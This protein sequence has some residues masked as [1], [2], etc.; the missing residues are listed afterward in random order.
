MNAY[1]H[2]LQLSIDHAL[3]VSYRR[4][5]SQ[6]N[7]S[8]VAHISLVKGTPFYGYYEGY[9]LYLK[10]Y[11]L[12][13]LHIA[14]LSDLLL[15][16]AVMKKVFQPYESHLQY[17]LQWMCDYNLYGCDYL[18][19]DKVKFRAPVP[20]YDEP[21]SSDHLWHDMSIPPESISD[22]VDVLRLSH[23]TVEV[24][25]HVQEIANRRQ[26]KARPIHRDFVERY[27]SVTSDER[28]VHSMAGLWRDETRRRKATM[29]DSDPNSTP[30]PPEVLISMS[31]QPR[32]SPRSGWIHEDEYMQVLR[33]II[34]QERVGVHGQKP[35]FESFAEKASAFAR[36]KSALE[37]V[38]DLY[39]E[40]LFR[41]ATPKSTIVPA[42]SSEA[43]NRGA[44]VDVDESL[45]FENQENDSIY[46][47]DQDTLI[48]PDAAAIVDHDAIEKT[49]EKAR[50]R[51]G[52]RK[53]G[54]SFASNKPK[55]V[56]VDS[57][58]YLPRGGPMTASELAE[59]GIYDANN[60]AQASQDKFAI[61]LD[62][63]NGVGR[64]RVPLGNHVTT[65]TAGQM[66]YKRRK[67]VPKA[68]V[69]PPEC[70]PANDSQSR[71]LG[72][73][74]DQPHA[75]E[76]M[77]AESSSQ[78][79]HLQRNGS[80]ASSKRSSNKLSQETIK[81]NV[82]NEKTWSF[83]VVKDPK[84]VGSARRSGQQNSTSQ[85]AVTPV[86]PP[87]VSIGSTK[88]PHD[89]P[90]A[91]HGE[92]SQGL[93]S[94][95]SASDAI[96]SELASRYSAG[97]ASSTGGVACY[98]FGTAPPTAASV[99]SEMHS[100]QSIPVLYQEAY[101]SDERDVPPRTREYAG[102]GFRLASNT[103]PYLPDFDPDGHSGAT[104]GAANLP[105]HNLAMKGYQ[106]RRR[107]CTL[108]AWEVLAIP[109]SRTEVEHWCAQEQKMLAAR[110]TSESQSPWPH[111]AAT[112]GLS[113]IDGPTQKHRHGFKFSQRRKSSAAPQ[114]AQYMSL[115]SL[116]IH[117]NNR[118]DLLPNPEQD[119]ITCV[120]W[121]HQANDGVRTGEQA[122]GTGDVGILV[123][124]EHGGLARRI[125][126]EAPVRIEEESTEL[127]L[128]NRMIDIV[129]QH[130]PDILTGYEVHDGSWGY[131]IERARRKYDYNL[132]DEFSR[133]KSQSHGRFG[134][135]N[136]RW[137][138]NHTSTIRVTGRHMINVWRAMRG[139]L[140]LLQYTLENVAFHLLH[141]RIPHY[142]HKD[143]T[144][145][146]KSSKPRDMAKVLDYYITRVQV[147][148]EILEKNE[149]ISRTSEQARILGVD[150]FSV[151]SRGSQF[152]VES[153]MF[154]IAK[155]EDYVLVSPSR[156]QVGQQNALECLPLVMEPQSD[157][158][159]SPL[160]VL[161]FQSL[162]PSIMIAYNYC[163]ST[164]LGRVVGWR[165]QNKMGFTDYQRPPQVLEL[166]QDHI[167]GRC[168]SR[169][170]RYVCAR[171][172]P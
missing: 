72:P 8:F 101:F 55:A 93:L 25:I 152:K 91:S 73:R 6:G 145:F 129:R 79:A 29:P 78:Q 104:V 151:F 128:I 149:L 170:R 136:D 82:N 70:P 13:P 168:M 71:N 67:L 38:E 94:G 11:L 65:R 146:W 142:S 150:F 53:E 172:E 131:L 107:T 123:L 132:C 163:Y 17:I 4:N 45:I 35:T 42:S 110:K 47:S 84:E 39:P 158:Y 36:I 125:S 37:S 141:K 31:A 109:P 161:D 7:V 100:S 160:L 115:M 137:G 9:K 169:E 23:C 167:N 90:P 77:D 21:D 52:G 157:F 34:A 112:T 26:I 66:P 98:V 124:S 130:D 46:G 155:A 74:G 59:L 49:D 153:L 166:L 22:E 30:F 113:Q 148:L 138:F 62:Y 5:T 24:D 27:S 20:S 144:A 41:M 51:A 43:G 14:R 143:L 135:D 119:E 96:V 171:A 54:K 127:G 89:E 156:K 76:P 154:R 2:R 57:D 120:F 134:K 33:E 92:S 159:T 118:D 116:E 88:A 81:S 32:S 95:S 139:E 60:M 121:C 1:I 102:R 10:V 111:K 28:L 106:K 61:P 122:E 140:N 117:V 83:S 162:Y 40:N 63:T 114:E 58:R 50:R 86:S 105:A 64:H 16:G 87:A 56:S 19:C 97:F 80:V 99:T 147:D 133:M 75:M 164:F 44:N 85:K 69:E 108:R 15:Q 12:N 3:A 68:D 165:G 103:L 126:R 18:I 48:A